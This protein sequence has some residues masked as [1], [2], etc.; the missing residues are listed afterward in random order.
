MAKRYLRATD[1][2]IKRNGR[3]L[4][5]EDKSKLGTVMDPGGS[6]R[7]ACACGWRARLST[8]RRVD[9]VHDLLDHINGEL[10]D[11]HSGSPEGHGTREG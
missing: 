11:T 3:V 8:S 1:V 5:N 9:A 7:A 6:W 2:L 4:S 10:D